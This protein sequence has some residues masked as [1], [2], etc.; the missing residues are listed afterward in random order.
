[1]HRAR[2]FGLALP[3]VVTVGA[4][5]AACD[6]SSNPSTDITLPDA[7]LPDSSPNIP[8][9]DAAV[10]DGGAPD[11]DAA[12]AQGISVLVVDGL[13]PKSGIRVI[14]HDATGAPTGGDT[15][16]ATGH[17]VSATTPS[18]VT[19]LTSETAADVNPVTFMGLTG[20]ETLRV[21][22]RHPQNE[23]SS[24]G[25]VSATHTTSAAVTNASMF[26]SS[27]GP[28]CGSNAS[29]IDSPILITVL[30]SCISAAN[31][32]L[33]T[34]SDTNGATLGFAF[35]KNV[36][37][38]TNNATVNVGPLAFTAKGSRTLAA[39]NLLDAEQYGNNV[40]AFAVVGTDPFYLPS[41]GNINQP[42]GVTYATPVG[43]ADAYQ[44]ELDVGKTAGG[45][46]ASTRILRREAAAAASAGALTSFDF[47]EALPL[48]QSVAVDI[49]AGAARP[50]VTITTAPTTN[51]HTGYARIR[52][53]GQTY[54]AQWTFVFPGDQKTFTVPALPPDAS[55]FAPHDAVSANLVIYLDGPLVPDFATGKKLP[56][57]TQGDLQ[58][59]DSY[60]AL[61]TN[62]KLLVTT[63]TPN[64]R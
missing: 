2:V 12:P 42:A 32:V 62:G 19:V 26:Y 39:T 13:L 44:S 23:E 50:V 15:T 58:L 5:V 35:M 47:N 45:F 25:I 16:D 51:A 11:A 9:S 56:I 38:P 61:P 43:F 49:T 54:G 57:P 14:Y 21:A 37:A 7:A 46:S 53:P 17:V 29:N 64:F 28:R 18:M 6:D 20:G 52:W 24:V 34:A 30:P 36:T 55:A 59:L 40:S 22:I 31:S 8:P 3:V 63:I 27:F 10:S 48:L 33:T 4:C 41:T 1:M 60:V